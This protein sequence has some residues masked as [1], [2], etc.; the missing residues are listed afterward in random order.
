[1]LKNIILILAVMVLLTGCQSGQ[2]KIEQNPG[3]TAA[4]QALEK[5]IDKFAQEE[6][7]EDNKRFLK[8]K[9]EIG[10]LYKKIGPLTNIDGFLG[11]KMSGTVD[12]LITK[13]E[14]L[15]NLPDKNV[16]KQLRNL[17]LKIEKKAFR[18]DINDE[19]EKFSK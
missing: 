14:K 6:K 5:T 11:S 7:S 18:Y 16:T 13:L 17:N 12:L 9:A 4:D 2:V 3:Q 8:M 19:I 1:M 15:S 10:L